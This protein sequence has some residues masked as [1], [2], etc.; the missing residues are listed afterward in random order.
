MKQEVLE[1]NAE[2]EE[3]AISMIKS[4]P[5]RIKYSDAVPVGYFVEVKKPFGKYSVYFLNN[6]NTE[7]I[8]TYYERYSSKIGEICIKPFIELGEFLFRIIAS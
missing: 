2:I 5:E 1:K 7:V 6:E 4:N 8:G 3:K